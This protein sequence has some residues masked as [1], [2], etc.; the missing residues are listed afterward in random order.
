MKSV[1]LNNPDRMLNALRELDLIEVAEHVVEQMREDVLA[2]GEYVYEQVRLTFRAKVNGAFET[3]QA[4]F[5][6]SESLDPPEDA[7]AEQRVQHME[8][9]SLE[10][11]G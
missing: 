1:V 4:V 5:F 8:F 7:E 10:T 3:M 9:Q 11:I 2:W 6:P